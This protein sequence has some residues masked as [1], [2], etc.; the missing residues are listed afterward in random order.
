MVTVGW[1]SVNFVFAVSRATA[2]SGG[3]R[4]LWSD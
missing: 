3:V 2:K 1:I 4:V